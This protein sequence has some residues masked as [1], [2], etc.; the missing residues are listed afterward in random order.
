MLFSNWSRGTP[1]ALIWVQ[2]GRKT[3]R[4]V[5]H[6]P[7]RLHHTDGGIKFSWIG[8]NGHFTR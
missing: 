7:N 5:Q 2:G 4:N 1:F 6:V 8:N 3:A